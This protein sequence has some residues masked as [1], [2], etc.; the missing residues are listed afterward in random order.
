MTATWTNWAGDQHAR[1]QTIERP[2]SVAEVSQIIVQAVNT[3]RVIRVVGAGH[4]FGDL[5]CTDGVLIS[6]DNLSGL[7]HYD[8]SS[9]LA[10][11]AG[12]TRLY[13]LNR[14]LDSHGRA[15]ANLG[16]INVQSV[17]GAIS[18]ATHG[19]G[20]KL[21]NLA[22][23]VA[24]LEIVTADG[25]VRTISGGEELQAAR[26][27][28]GA[29][30]V[31]SAVTLRTVPSFRLHNIDKRCPMDETLSRLDEFVTC[32]DHFEFWVFPHA[33][34]AL[35]RA[36]NR[37]PALPVPRSRLGSYA[38]EF[39]ENRVLDL[40]CRVGRRFPGRI[41]A[42]NRFVTAAMLGGE[43]IDT[44]HRIFSSVRDVRF[45]ESEW[46]MP[47]EAAQSA[48]RE[49]KAASEKFDVNFPLEVRFVAAD[50]DSFLSPAWGRETCYVATHTYTGMEW[51]RFLQTVQDIALAH[52]GRPHWGKRH[53]LE[54]SALAQLYPMWDR[55][56]NIRAALDPGG[57][58]ANEHV[59]RVL[60]PVEAR[61]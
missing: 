3:D 33:D 15:L 36:N 53:T 41:P 42:L 44:S 39:M 37:T 11:V 45:T 56:Q 24:A 47:R 28:I 19:T 34:D 14:L 21:G 48:V 26:V 46:A 58:F 13:E 25:S 1:P 55:F 38:Q 4:S 31:I 27:S 23:Q 43:R 5:V 2:S 49:I 16:D 7:L 60:G 32:N 9:G 29:L 61:R 17:A 35:C 20:V 30:G 10:T 57:R 40:V 6:L 51:R 52:G 18:T 54:A 59:W 8:P 12:G 50:E 22:T